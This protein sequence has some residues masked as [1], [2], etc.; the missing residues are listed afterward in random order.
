MKIKRALFVL[1]LLVISLNIVGCSLAPAENNKA[2]TRVVT[3]VWGRKVEIP[4]EVKKIICLG[5]GA[6]R[7][8]SYLGVVDMMTGSEDHD[9]KNFTVLRDYN[10]VYHD[11]LKKMPLVGKGGGSGNNNA[12]PEKIIEVK[13]DVILA[14]FSPEAA[15][16]LAKQTNIPVVCVRYISNN[17]VDETF[18]NAMRVFADVVG[19]QE[20]CEKVLS[21]IDDCKKDLNGRTANIPNNEKPK[22]YTGAVTFNGRHGF[23]GTY[24]NFGPFTGIN[25]LNVADEVKK[26]GYFEA[27]LEKVVV[28]D[29]DI[30]FLDPGNMNLVSDEYATNTGYFDNLRAIREGRV[31]TMPSFN[32]C[33]TNITYAIMNSYYAGTILFPQ[34]FADV[35]I[36]KKSSEILAFFLGKDI[37]DTMAENGLYYGRIKISE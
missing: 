36:A 26:P 8:A 29:P 14:G 22:V 32:N 4:A 7:M 35:D 23:A 6:P 16:E 10:P 33:G 1:A 21:F 25:A 24:S 2:G 11:K 19:A 15:D 37:Y 3:D 34:Q 13:P 28:W 12:Y 5:S 17:F 31:Y 18:Y 27:D 20:R 30:I 9:A